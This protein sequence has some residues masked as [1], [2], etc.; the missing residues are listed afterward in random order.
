MVLVIAEALAVGASMRPPGFLEAPGLAPQKPAPNEASYTYPGLQR[1]RAE[2]CMLFKVGWILYIYICICIIV[3]QI[4]YY[5][6]LR[7]FTLHYIT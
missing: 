5:V 3:Y 2:K 7:Y 6:L 4:L 1:E